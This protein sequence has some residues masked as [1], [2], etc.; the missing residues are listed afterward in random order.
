[1]LACLWTLLSVCEL[2]CSH[3]ELLRPVAVG[4]LGNGCSWIFSV[5]GCGCCL[6]WG[7]LCDSGCLAGVC[8]FGWLLCCTVFIGNCLCYEC[9]SQTYIILN[10]S[11]K[12]SHQYTDVWN[13]QEFICGAEPCCELSYT[14]K[15]SF[16]IFIEKKLGARKIP[17]QL[18]TLVVLPEDLHLIPSSLLSVTLVPGELVSS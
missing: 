4:L 8:S 3:L 11:L 18:G 2:Y 17:Q 16:C 7:I 5:S 6:S 13:W 10:V 9:T 15:F 12:A 1:M 14:P